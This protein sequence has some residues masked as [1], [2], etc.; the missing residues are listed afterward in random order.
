MKKLRIGF[1]TGSA[2]AAAAKAAIIWM[3]QKKDIKEVEVPLPNGTRMKIPVKKIGLS[4][5]GVFAEVVKDAGDDPDVTHK[6]TIICHVK[7]NRDSDSG[8][9]IKGGK[10]VGIVTKPGLPVKV[11]EPAINPVPRAQIKEAVYEG[12][13]EANLFPSSVTVT[14]EV[15]NGE[16]IAKKTLNPK[17]GII[18]GISILGT[19]GTVIPYSNEAYKKTISVVMDMAR[20]AKVDTIV[21]STGGRSERFV[22]KLYPMLD[23]IC[24]VQ[25]ADFFSF[26][27]K[28]AAKR[29][30]KH[31][32]YACFFG[33]LLKMAQGIPYTHAKSS[34]IDFNLLA[35]WCSDWGI[36]AE[37][38]KKIKNANTAAQ[39][40]EVI[41]SYKN[42]RDIISFIV[43]KA[44]SQARKFLGPYPQITYNLFSMQGEIICQMGERGEA[45]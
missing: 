16:Q 33:K 3:A 15:P 13:K 42:A 34:K 24:F 43:K 19:R 7:I 20:A 36:K 23:D 2:A 17:L 14:I 44:I 8:V 5:N 41:K 29:G 31:V 22:K 35:K 38:V 27:L 18:G 32:I 10:G 25:V 1:T 26:S 11:G 4:N 9:I 40:F 28:E 37:D 21:L 39:A 12:L 30:F 45:E 6:A